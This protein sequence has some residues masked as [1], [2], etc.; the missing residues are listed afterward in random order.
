MTDTLILKI[1]TEEK[2]RIVNKQS[3]KE[4]VLTIEMKSGK[5]YTFKTDTAGN[6][7][8]EPELLDGS[9]KIGVT[10]VDAIDE[11]KTD[12]NGVVTTTSK[13][14][15]TYM[16]LDPADIDAMAYDFKRV[17]TNATASTTTEPA[18]TNGE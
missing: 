7:Y 8:R 4:L 13:Q 17:T 6:F 16:Y 12:V 15:V 2:S 14:P 3:G 11:T 10:D 18:D 9:L 1:I 5:K